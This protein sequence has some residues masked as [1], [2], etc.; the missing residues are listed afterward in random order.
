M[1]ENEIKD[2]RKYFGT[3]KDNRKEKNRDMLIS[4]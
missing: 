3:V 2:I 1:K 4:I